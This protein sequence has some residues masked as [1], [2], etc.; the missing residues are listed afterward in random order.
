MAMESEADALTQIGTDELEG[1]VGSW[2]LVLVFL[3][4]SCKLG[5]EVL[6]WLGLSLLCH[7]T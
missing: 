1:K 6:H 7:V 2:S 4:F 3:S 5:S